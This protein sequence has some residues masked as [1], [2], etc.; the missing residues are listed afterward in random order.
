MD[1]YLGKL[2]RIDLTKERILEENIPEESILRMY[3][4]GF[5]LG[6][7]LLYD[8]LPL[9][10]SPLDPENP[11][12]FMTGPLT[13]TMVPSPTNTT[14]TT[15]NSDTGFTAG[16]SHSHGYWGPNLKFAGYD[17]LIIQ[18]VAEKPVYLWI[19]DEEVEIRDGSKIWGKDTH[20]TEDLVKKEL[21]Q[22]KAS[23]AAIG[24]AGENLCDGALV[25]ND[26]NHSFSH[27]GIGTVM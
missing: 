10:I 14:C 21:G 15:L 7:R 8:E 19:C 17:G 4:G 11:L 27:S 5:G 6:L 22:P 12:I 26:K 2:L 23:V 13:G 1:G 9:G 25:E 3:I 20:E 16:R 24:P 18:G